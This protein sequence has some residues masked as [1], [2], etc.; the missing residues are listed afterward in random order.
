MEAFIKQ[1]K[2]QFEQVRS[3][4]QYLHTYPTVLS[5][6]KIEDLITPQQLYKHQE[7]WIRLCS[8]YDNMEKDFFKPYWIPIQRGYGCFI[9]ISDS[10]F[11][12]IESFFNCIKKPY[13]WEKIYLFKSIKELMLAEDNKID[14]ETY[15]NDKEMEKYK[16]YLP[17]LF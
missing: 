3:I 2:T 8:K 12:V 11:P 4:L 6:L 16:K 9:D 17:F 10:K 15:R 13:C 1:W 5:D 14:L 7:D